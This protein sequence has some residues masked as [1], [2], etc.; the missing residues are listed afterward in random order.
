MVIVKPNNFHMFYGIFMGLCYVFTSM[1]IF[2][3]K[4]CWETPYGEAFYFVETIHLIR[5][6]NQVNGF[7][8]VWVFAVMNIREEDYRFCCFNINKLSC[9]VIFRKGS[10]TTTLLVLYLSTSG[11]GKLVVSLIALHQISFFVHMMP[12]FHLIISNL[13]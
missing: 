11:G 9:Y 10:C 6:A 13:Y 2:N 8:I 1:L 4:V 3:F 7:C 12:E 5:G